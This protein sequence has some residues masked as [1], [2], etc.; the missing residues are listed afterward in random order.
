MEGRGGEGRG[1]EGRGGE[2]RGEGRG[3]REGEGKGGERGGEGRDS[4]KQYTGTLHYYA[5]K[6]H[7][8]HNNFVVFTFCVPHLSRSRFT[9]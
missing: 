7:K 4:M 9:A 2:G 5:R 1:G 6:S 3:E 8:L